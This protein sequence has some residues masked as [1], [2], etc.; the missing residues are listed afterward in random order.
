MTRAFAADEAAHPESR[1]KSQ[2]SRSDK[3]DGGRR[4]NLTS[5]ERMTGGNG[6]AGGTRGGLVGG[7]TTH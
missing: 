5:V 4:Q 6:G 1:R 2:H 7:H 3:L